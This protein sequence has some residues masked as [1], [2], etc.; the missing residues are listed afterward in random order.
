M[1]KEE[2]SWTSTTRY[3]DV[4]IPTKASSPLEGGRASRRRPRAGRRW[5]VVDHEHR[6]RRR[7]LLQQ[8]H[9]RAPQAGRA[10]AGGGSVTVKRP[11][12]GSKGVIFNI[13]A[14]EGY[15]TTS[16]AGDGALA[17]DP[18]ATGTTSS[19]ASPAS[20]Y[21]HAD[22]GLPDVNPLTA[23]IQLSPS[24]LKHATVT[25]HV[26]VGAAEMISSDAAAAVARRASRTTRGRA[27]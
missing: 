21:K 4:L 3:P 11:A 13:V 7:G 5:H 18:K 27:R 23:K 19:K 9:A 1:L 26:S 2:A 20:G 16:G 14:L 12:G 15:E 6:Q 24:E 25:K 17:C 10:G 22:P 8:R